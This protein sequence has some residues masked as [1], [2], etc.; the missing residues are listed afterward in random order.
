MCFG[1]SRGGSGPAR[2]L[3]GEYCGLYEHDP[4][5][6]SESSP[7]SSIGIILCEGAWKARAA[8][9]PG[10][11]RRDFEK[12]SSNTLDG[13]DEKSRPARGAL[14]KGS[15]FNIIC[16]AAET[17]GAPLVSHPRVSHGCPHR[18]CG[19]RSGKN[20]ACGPAIS[21]APIFESGQGHRSF[22]FDDAR[23]RPW[24]AGVATLSASIIR[25]RLPLRVPR[26]PGRQD[27]RQVVAGSQRRP[28]AN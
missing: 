4:A 5:R 6:S 17:V 12:P 22:V 9:A 3:A 28:Y 24:F 21:S 16:G 27:L 7:R 19:R 20:L 1:S 25:A 26:P 23:S 11:T 18:R 8:L 15:R 2:R 14:P 10:N 13:A